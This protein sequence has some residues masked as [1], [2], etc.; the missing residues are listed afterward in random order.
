VVGYEMTKVLFIQFVKHLNKLIEG[1]KSKVETA[2]NLNPFLGWIDLNKERAVDVVTLASIAHYGLV[3]NVFIIKKIIVEK[4]IRLQAFTEGNHRTGQLLQNF[5]LM[6]GGYPPMHLYSLKEY[7]DLDKD[8][9]IRTDY[10]R[11]VDIRP[12]IRFLF[13]NLE[14]TMDSVKDEK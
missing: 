7:Y 1:D 3:L 5:L 4:Q 14:L 9:K 13:A 12:F 11:G 2:R 6:S 8:A 10:A